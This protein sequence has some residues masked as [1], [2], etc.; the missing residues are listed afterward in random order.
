M[1]PAAVPNTTAMPSAS[2]QVLIVCHSAETIAVPVSSVTNAS[3][4]WLAGGK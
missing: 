3:A 1:I 2:S 4:I